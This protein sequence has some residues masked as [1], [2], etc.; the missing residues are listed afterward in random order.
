MDDQNKSREQLIA[1]LRQLRAER[2]QFE[3]LE[4]IPDQVFR[5]GPDGTMI[6]YFQGKGPAPMLPPEQFLGRRLVEVFPNALG[7]QLL[8]TVEAAAR[9][10]D[11]QAVEYVLDIDGKPE[12]YEARC[13]PASQG[14]VLCVVREITAR[15]RTEEDLRTS[16]QLL[17]DSQRIAHI[18]S[19]RYDFAS[20]AIMFTDE[21]FRIFGYAPCEIT[22]TFELFLE[23]VFPD[24][25][26]H[27]KVKLLHSASTGETYLCEHRIF[28][29]D[30]EVRKVLCTGQVMF[31]E[32]GSPIAMVG[33]TQDITERKALEEALRAQNE[34]LLE[35]DRLKSSFV[36]SVSHELRTPLTSIMGYAE[37]LEDEVAGSL[38]PDQLAF[39]TQ[40][41]RGAVRLGNLVDDLLDFARLQSGAFKL[42]I[43]DVELPRKLSEA[44]DAL[45]PQ[46]Q[47]AKVELSLDLV[48]ELPILQGDP[49][50]IGQ[51]LTNLIGNAIKFTPPGGRVVVSARVSPDAVRVEVRD[52][53]IG[54]SP[55]HQ[56]K[57]FSKFFQIDPSTT[58]E[59]GGAGLGLSITKA[60]V[61]AH[62]GQIGMTSV[63]G[64]G[65]RF[66]F[67]LPLDPPLPQSQLFCQDL[68]ARS[69]SPTYQV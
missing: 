36:N 30:G 45:Y 38:N 34:Q 42:Q 17:A 15:K 57:L 9:T 20:N 13:V 22:P 5:V 59:K 25:R 12:S 24:E 32:S 10:G 7:Q 47:D 16:Q 46:A 40:I 11:L 33:A 69:P 53:G 68:R 37:F 8:A 2:A 63:L 21:Q 49:E 48:Q 56:A 52:T 43:R 29:R 23:H 51:I 41:Q 66:W 19:W 35:L 3:H 31:N 60:L 4:A 6:G 39:V 62:G 50:R 55:G 18:G 1:E 67:E 61:E 54:I 26:E 14:E 44:L 58:R 27:V 64:E 28:R 65:S